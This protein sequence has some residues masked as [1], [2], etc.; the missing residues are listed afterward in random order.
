M[1]ILDLRFLRINAT[2]WSEI[3]NDF[4]A[5]EIGELENLADDVRLGLRAKTIREN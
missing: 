2:G 5:N 3:G 1:K 4:L